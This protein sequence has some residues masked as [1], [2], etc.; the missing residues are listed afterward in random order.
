MRDTFTKYFIYYGMQ[1]VSKYAL[2]EI[3]AEAQC[4]CIFLGIPER[5]SQ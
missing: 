3:K 4:L 5:L 1:Q 2:W